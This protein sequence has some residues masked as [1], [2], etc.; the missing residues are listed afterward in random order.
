MTKGLNSPSSENLP[1]PVSTFIGR[2]KEIVTVKELVLESR[3]VTLTG[4]GG[5]G[6]TRLAIKIARELLEKFKNRVWFIELASLRDP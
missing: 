1:T 2:E 4:A 5:S 3:L 6:K